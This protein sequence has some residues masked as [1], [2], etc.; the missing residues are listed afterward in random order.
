MRLQSKILV[1]LEVVQRFSLAIEMVGRLDTGAANIRLCQRGMVYFAM[2]T[3]PKES[4][5]EFKAYEAADRDTHQVIE[6]LRKLLDAG[7]DHA[8][9]ATYEQAL[10]TFEGLGSQAKASVDAAGST[11]RLTL[12]ERRA[13]QPWRRSQAPSS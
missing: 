8:R 11:T 10:A 13:R 5:A 1:N 12:C 6:E 2:Q 9:L 4:A 3:D 7:A